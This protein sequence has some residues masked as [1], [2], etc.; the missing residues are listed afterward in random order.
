[1]DTVAEGKVLSWLLLVYC[2]RRETRERVYLSLVFV[3][4][5]QDPKRISM[6]DLATASSLENDDL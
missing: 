5:E 4:I 2:E 3:L 1:M 6:H